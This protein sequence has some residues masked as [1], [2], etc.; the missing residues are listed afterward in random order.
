ME[1]D[2][3]CPKCSAEF[4]ARWAIADLGLKRHWQ[5]HSIPPRVRC[6][7]CAAEFLAK[8]IRYFGFMSAGD[9]KRAL[10]L[11]IAIMGLAAIGLIFI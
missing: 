6:P 5:W 1:G 7:A 8:R 3:I 11:A 2:E 9:L 4:P 10:L